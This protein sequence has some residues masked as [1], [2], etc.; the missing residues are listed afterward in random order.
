[1]FEG[2]RLGIGRFMHVGEKPFGVVALRFPNVARYADAT[3]FCDAKLT[4]SG[5]MIAS[6]RHLLD[7][8]DPGTSIAASIMRTI[9]DQPFSERPRMRQK[10]PLTAKV[11]DTTVGGSAAPVH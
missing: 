8:A 2:E 9:Y 4:R 10:P 5:M 3:A 7:K 6:D 11:G 1:M